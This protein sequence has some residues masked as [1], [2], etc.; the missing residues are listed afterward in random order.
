MP[1]KSN[2]KKRS[3]SDSIS[4]HTGS[5]P[6]HSTWPWWLFQNK[7]NAHRAH[8]AQASRTQEDS[9]PSWESCGRVSWQEQHRPPGKSPAPKARSIAN[10]MAELS[11]VVTWF[12]P[13]HETPLPVSLSLRIHFLPGIVC[14]FSSSSSPL[15]LVRTQ[16]HG[17]AQ[18]SQ[19]RMVTSLLP[20][21][22]ASCFTGW[23]HVG[24]LG[25]G[26]ITVKFLLWGCPF[27]HP[28]SISG[29]GDS[30]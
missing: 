5:Y 7:N 11:P 25:D 19:G 17:L 23:E 2:F 12:L 30:Q 13:S 20:A 29:Y 27:F 4:N 28:S 18:R 14:A 10:S 24:F 1:N 16:S 9:P 26:A 22:R 21:G 6:F 3:S 8:S 15:R